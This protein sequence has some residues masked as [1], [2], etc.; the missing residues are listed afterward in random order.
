M[1]ESRTAAIATAFAVIFIANCLF[2]TSVS[3]FSLPTTRKWTLGRA[4]ED[5]RSGTI[6]QDHG[7][8]LGEEESTGPG[9]APESA[10]AA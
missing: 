6:P 3:T 9:Y 8:R 2:Q 5:G 4:S 1:D 7:G 10:L